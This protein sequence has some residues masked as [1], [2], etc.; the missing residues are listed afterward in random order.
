[1]SRVENDKGRAKVKSVLHQCVVCKKWTGGSYQLPEMPPLPWVRVAEA[2]PF[3]FIAVDYFGSINCFRD[4]NETLDTVHVAIFVCLV[5]RAIHLELA[6][7]LTADEFLMAFIRFAS[8]RGV[9][10]LVYSDHGTNLKFV[11]RLVGSETKIT[12][13]D[14]RRYFT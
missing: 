12:D 5:T 14:V 9:P 7:D 4:D 1:M 2:S 6:N 13:I 3:L 11:Q 10:K 8:R